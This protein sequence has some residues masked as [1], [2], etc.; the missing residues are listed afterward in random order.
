[1]PYFQ[2]SYYYNIN[3]QRPVNILT[4]DDYQFV[5]SR[6]IVARNEKV[7]KVDR[8]YWVVIIQH[9]TSRNKFA[10]TFGL[11]AIRAR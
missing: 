9:A 4:Q 11:R 1:M 10:E 6:N 8:I 2:N 5:S 3:F 7:S